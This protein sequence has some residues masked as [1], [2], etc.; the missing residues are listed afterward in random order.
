MTKTINPVE[1]EQKTGGKIS[2]LY[3]I[4]TSCYTFINHKT[5]KTYVIHRSILNSRF[6]DIVDT[7]LQKWRIK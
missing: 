6:W 2:L 1:W 4:K 5:Q 7:L 3:D